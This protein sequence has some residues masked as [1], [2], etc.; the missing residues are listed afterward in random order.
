MKYLEETTGHSDLTTNEIVLTLV[1]TFKIATNK[2][3]VYNSLLKN[4]DVHKGTAGYKLMQSGIDQLLPQNNKQG[5]VLIK[6]NQP[7][8]SRSILLK[9]IFTGMNGDIKICDPYF[10]SATLDFVCRNFNKKTNISF[11]TT[12]KVKDIPR[13]SLKSQLNELKKEGYSIEVRIYTS[14]DIHDRYIINKGIFWLS[15]TSL[16][17]IGNKESFLVELGKDT[18]ESMTSTFNNRWKASSSM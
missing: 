8:T 3:L 11:L 7:F 14:S 9:D 17:G 15:G 1:N 18:A 2:K 4:K 10:D 12:S 5:V 16:N 13:G 6:A